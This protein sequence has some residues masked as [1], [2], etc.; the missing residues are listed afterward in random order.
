MEVVGQE[1]VGEKGSKGR[2]LLDSLWASPSP[3]ET[4]VGFR[5]SWGT[6]EDLVS[7]TECL[8]HGSRSRWDGAPAPPVTAAC[9]P[10]PGTSPPSSFQEMASLDHG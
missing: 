2:H 9:S 8:L 1:A 10:A 4:M 6:R 5:G 7:H 3:V